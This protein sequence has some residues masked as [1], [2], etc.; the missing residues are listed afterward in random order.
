[1]SPRAGFTGGFGT[2]GAALGDVDGNGLV[3][4]VIGAPNAPDTACQSIGI[5][6]VFLA[7][8][9]PASGT[10]GWSRSSIP[11]PTLNAGFGAFGWSAATIPG[12]ANI[13]IGE[14]GRL[15]DGTAAGQ[16]YV[17]RVVP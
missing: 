9:T 15:I 7:Q 1:M 13:L 17:Y 16:V 12:S 6:Y 3:D 10:V 4:I 2:R 11:P 5:A 14:T 8:G